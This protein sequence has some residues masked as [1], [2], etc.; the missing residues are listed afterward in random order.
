MGHCRLVRG[1]V[2]VSCTVNAKKR[3]CGAN[4]QGAVT[5]CLRR[6]TGINKVFFYRTLVSSWCFSTEKTQWS[7][8]K[9]CVG[10]LRKISLQHAGITGGAFPQAGGNS[11]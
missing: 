1:E 10:E 4:E 3:V 11:S 2:F 5:V 7:Q 8:W 6:L 9:D